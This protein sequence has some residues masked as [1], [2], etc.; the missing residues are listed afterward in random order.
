MVARGLPKGGE[1]KGD[2]KHAANDLKHTNIEVI[3][4][5]A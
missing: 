5:M 4:R 1:E 2:H 3:K